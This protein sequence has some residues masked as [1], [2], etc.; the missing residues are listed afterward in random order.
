MDWQRCIGGSNNDAASSI[1]QTVDGGYLLA[2]SSSS[3]DGDVEVNYGDE[4]WYVAKLD[5]I[6]S[7]E[8]KQSFGGSSFE[9]PYA[10]YQSTD[11]GAII[12]G[13]TASSDVYVTINQGNVDGWIIKLANIMA[14]DSPSK[15][16][17][18]QVYPN[19]AS[20]STSVFI[21]P[22]LMHKS[23]RLVNHLGQCIASGTFVSTELKL[24]LVG[25]PAG[26]YKI[27]TESFVAGATFIVVH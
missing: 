11:E 22:S 15:R 16:E 1:V 21:D 8:W 5:S 27:V 25:M 17:K 2:G 24:S 10:V 23:Y 7:I 26:L 19:P 4:D 13:Y 3:A 18:M 20:Q 12:A 14:L 9:Y 6:G